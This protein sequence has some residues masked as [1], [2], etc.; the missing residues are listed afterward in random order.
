MGL[1][2]PVTW[3][4]WIH[5]VSQY[6]TPLYCIYIYIYILYVYIYMYIICIYI[7]DIHTYRGWYMYI[8]IYVYHM[9]IY[10]R[11]TYLQR[12]VYDCIGWYVILSYGIC[13]SPYVHH[14]TPLP[15]ILWYIYHSVIYIRVWCRV[16]GMWC[17]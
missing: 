1:R 11:Y 15:Y 14:I 12:V 13:T 10:S 9:Y 5:K 6:Y 4:T 16:R 2:H 17:T 8:Y 3:Y 7:V